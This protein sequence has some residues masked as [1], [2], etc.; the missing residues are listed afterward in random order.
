VRCYGDGPNLKSSLA[1]RAVIAHR[2]HD[3]E[4]VLATKQI[5]ISLIIR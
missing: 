5:M 4:S 3:R 1:T 2:D